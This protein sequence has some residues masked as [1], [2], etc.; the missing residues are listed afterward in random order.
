MKLIY[1]HTAQEGRALIWII[2]QLMVTW[3]DGG[4]EKVGHNPA[5]EEGSANKQP[6]D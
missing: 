5:T 4:K 3:R 6:R 1:V 2:R